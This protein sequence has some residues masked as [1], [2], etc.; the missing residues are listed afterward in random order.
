MVWR[1]GC[2]VGTLSL[3]AAGAIACGGK[4]DYVG[5]ALTAGAGVGAAG[6]NRAITKDCWGQCLH[7]LVCDHG[8]GLCVERAPCGGRCG[9]DET[10]EEGAVARCVPAFGFTTDAGDGG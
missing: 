8:S 10:C 6:V 1:F 2:P 9:P 4:S 7:G 5:A 3:L